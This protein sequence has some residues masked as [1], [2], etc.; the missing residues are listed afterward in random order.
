[1]TNGLENVLWLGGPPGAGKSTVARLLARRHGLRWYN[2]DAHT[3]EHRDRAVAAG[4]SAAI[5]FEEM[6]IP[7]R[8]SASLEDRLAMSLHRVRGPMIHDDLRAL[9]TA[10]LTITEGTPITPEAVGDGSALWLIPTPGLRR[11]RLNERNLPSGTRELYEH[12]SDVIAEEVEQLRD[13][14]VVIDESW[15]LEQVAAEVERRFGAMLARGPSAKDPA[16]RRQL[17]RYANRASVD[18]YRGYFARPWARALGDISEVVLPFFC[19]CAHDTCDEQVSLAV[20]DF[21][22]P[23]DDTSPPLLAEGH[24]PVEERRPGHA[25]SGRPVRGGLRRQA[26]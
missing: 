21:P 22:A 24:D 6:T 11:K 18:Q 19:E 3:W 20:S 15:S 9:P 25:S 13:R 7:D 2:S 5:R 4:H 10:P 12:L 26:Q 23:P 1:M 17:I 14:I 8:R 16:E